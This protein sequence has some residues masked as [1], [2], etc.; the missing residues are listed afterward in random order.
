MER[1]LAGKTAVVT[2]ASSG[3]G[4]GIAMRLA[5]HGADVV[6]ADVRETPRLGGTPTHQRI[7]DET[8]AT[9]RYVDCD[10]TDPAELEAA[11]EVAD[12]LGGLDVMVNNAGVLGPDK[13]FVEIEP[14]EYRQ[15][16]DVNLFGVFYG[17]QAAARSMLQRESG[18]SIVNI[19]STAAY[20]T[21]GGNAPYPA[22][23]G[24]V[25]YLTYALADELGPENV[26]VNAIHPA[27]MRTALT[28]EDADSAMGNAEK[29]E[30]IKQDI[31]LQKFPTP[32]DI[33]DA[34]VFLASDLASCITAESLLV[35]GGVVN[36][37]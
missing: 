32:E 7:A 11:V 5:E 20:E 25:R 2:G 35:D 18:G 9:S 37:G 31:P 22:A 29:E 24:G 8:D 36:T 28:M 1:L 4:R 12:E 26:R 33:G 27:G 23:K 34:T 13:P 3:N 21:Y 19:S 15:A 16:M 17:A 6:V 10:V 30:E 14:D